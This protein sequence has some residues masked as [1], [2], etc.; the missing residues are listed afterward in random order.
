MKTRIT[1]FGLVV[2]LA[3]FGILSAATAQ[4]IRC[5]SDD[6]RRHYCSADTRRGVQLSRQISGSPCTQGYSWGFDQ[7]GIWVD[8]GCRGEFTLAGGYPG[9]G[10]PG[11]GYPGSPGYP[12]G[13]FN[14]TITCS[15]ENGSRRYCPT[16]VSGGVRLTRQISGSPCTQGSTWGWDQR[17]I[18]VDRGCR[19]EFLVASGA[20]AYPPNPGYPG[21]GYTNEITCSSDDGGRK[22]CPTG[23]NRHISLKQQISGSPCI[24]GQTWGRDGNG[25]WVDRGCRAVFSIRR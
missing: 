11:G 23:P 6:G 1:M 9:G 5:S 2:L 18:W 21:G 22:Y 15:S 19:A 16:N 24:S 20:G 13:G 8:R 4:V 12:G 14:Q 17:G 25:V 3:L 10:Y 7:R